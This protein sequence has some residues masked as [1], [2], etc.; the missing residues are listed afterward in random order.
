MNKKVFTNHKILTKI[1]FTKKYIFS[2]ILMIKMYN[3]A[4]I[5]SFTQCFSNN[6]KKI[7]SWHSYDVNMLIDEFGKTF[8]RYNKFQENA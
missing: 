8:A 4:L 1:L 7:F 6:N 5:K 2:V 3:E